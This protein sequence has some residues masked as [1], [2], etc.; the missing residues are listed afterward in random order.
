MIGA[1][2]L[3]GAALWFVSRLLAESLSFWPYLVISFVMIVDLFDVL[4]RLHIVRR[5][6]GKSPT[7]VPLGSDALNPYQMKLH[8]RPWA[9]IVS[10]HNAEEELD[11]FLTAVAP[12]RDRLWVIDD[13]STD[14]TWARLR[15]AGIQCVRSTVNRKKPGALKDLLHQLPP[16]IETVG[17]VDPDCVVIQ[18]GGA[19]PTV[20]ERS[21][22]QFQRSGY[23]A[24]CP[25]IRV[26]QDGWL[27]RLQE[28]EYAIT[29]AVGRMSLAERN[30]TSG[31]AFYRR[32]ALE[33]VFRKHKLSVYAEDLRNALLLLG[34]GEGI[35][36]DSRVL[37]ETEGKRTVYSWFSQR[38]GWYFG[39]IKVYTE[40]FD[41]IRR[42]ARDDLF[43]TY[44]YWIYMGV[45]GLLLHP[46]R[47][48][49]LLLSAIAILNGLDELL[50]I[51]AIPNG[52]WTDP[53]YFLMAYAK[54][55]ALTMFLLVL[56]VPRGERARM[57][58]TAALYYL[59]QLL[60]IIPTT[61]GYL[62]WIGLRLFGRRLYRDHFQDEES[63]VREFRDQYGR[64]TP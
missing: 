62:N 60:H 22:F 25:R 21:I 16:E 44:H 50:A 47:A 23:S 56:A 27:A 20:L 61:L 64:G 7:S 59:Y 15:Q 46:V 52:R 37:I 12:Y 5:R 26:R 13:A 10:V 43:F 29:F 49:A 17:I 40:N 1:V 39:F 51:G 18:N 38:V 36:Y 35:Y 42:C 6:S 34:H 33:H 14:G 63:L 57:V 45:L 4:A 9:L 41:M 31:V 55:T 54:Y 11:D 8:L 2:L 58:P 32:D 24:F 3:M 19:D 48:A 30:V 53:I 28:L